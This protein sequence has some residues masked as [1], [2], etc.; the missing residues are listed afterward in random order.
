MGENKALPFY[1]KTVIANTS[2]TR[3]VKVIMWPQT[4]MIKN[5]NISA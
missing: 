1:V 3:N 5:L 2:Q 4:L